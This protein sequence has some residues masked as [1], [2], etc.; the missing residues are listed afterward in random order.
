MM[1]RS[2]HTYWLIFVALIGALLAGCNGRL[3]AGRLPNLHHR[4][5]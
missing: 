1:V 3:G 2:K 5:G 4:A